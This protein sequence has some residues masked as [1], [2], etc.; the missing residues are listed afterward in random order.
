LAFASGCLTKAVFRSFDRNQPAKRIVDRSNLLRPLAL[1][2]LQ[3][4]RTDSGTSYRWSKSKAPLTSRKAHPRPKKYAK[5][6]KE[7]Q[8]RIDDIHRRPQRA[9][10]C[11]GRDG[12]RQNRDSRRK[13]DSFGEA[14]E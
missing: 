4:F 14:G 3:W 7:C 13:P 2:K 10:A 5:G 6:G 12:M 8:Q 9:I 11:F 1:E